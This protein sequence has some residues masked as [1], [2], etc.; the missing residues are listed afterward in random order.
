MVRPIPL[1]LRRRLSDGSAAARQRLDSAAW[2]S[3]LTPATLRRR[4]G[5]S[6]AV[7][8]RSGVTPATA[9]QRR[10]GNAAAAA[11]R[12]RSGGR[13]AETSGDKRCPTPANINSF[14]TP[15]R[16]DVSSSAGPVDS[17]I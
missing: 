16:D 12:R 11:E 7:R 10:G 15:A 2:R 6:A 4:V 14:A 17:R 1:S 8:C 9:R 3:S 13:K 5:G